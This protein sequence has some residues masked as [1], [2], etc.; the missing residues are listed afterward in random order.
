MPETD[1]PPDELLTP[2]R[3]AALLGVTPDTIRKWANEDVLPSQRVRP[4]SHRRFKR[5]DV[6]ALIERAKQAS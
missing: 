2:Q 3:A 6:E 4:G 5:S 1:P